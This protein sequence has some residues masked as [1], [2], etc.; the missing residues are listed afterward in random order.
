MSKTKVLNHDEKL[1]LSKFIK[2]KLDSANAGKSDA[3]DILMIVAHLTFP[4][5]PI[6]FDVQP[7]SVSTCETFVTIA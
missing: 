3:Y 6:T 4:G 2:D 5:R 7:R 1:A